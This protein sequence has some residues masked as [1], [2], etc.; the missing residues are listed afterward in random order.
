MFYAIKV[1]YYVL[2]VGDRIFVQLI[3]QCF[4]IKSENKAI[5][6]RAK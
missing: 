1:M 2:F 6:N 4:L 3:I 5:Q